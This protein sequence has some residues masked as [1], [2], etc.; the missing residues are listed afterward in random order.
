MRQAVPQL[1]PAGDDVT[2]PVPVPPFWTVSVLAGE[3][4][5][6]QVMS[7]VSVTAT[8]LVV[9]LQSWPQPANVTPGSG[10]AVSVTVVPLANRA[11]QAVP[12][13]MAFPGPD[14]TVPVALPCNCTVNA[15]A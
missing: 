10:L 5:A 12:Q 6:T 14:V 9:P 11:E 3:K 8:V 13:F 1:I 15:G 2:V 7:A 4:L